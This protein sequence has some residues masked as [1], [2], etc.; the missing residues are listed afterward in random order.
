MK[1]R[2][3]GKMAKFILLY[4][5]QGTG[6][7]PMGPDTENRVGDHNIGGRGGLVYSVLQY[8]CEPGFVA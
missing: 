5:F 3:E 6:C 7:S 2:V 4:S 1:L 8:S